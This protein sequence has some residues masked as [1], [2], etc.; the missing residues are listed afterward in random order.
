MVFQLIRLDVFLKELRMRSNSMH[1]NLTLTVDVM[2]PGLQIHGDPTRLTQVFDN[3]IGNAIKY[4]PGS[5]VAISVDKIDE[6]V[7]ITVQD[8]GPG[9]GMEH[10]E[11]IFQRF[12]RVPEH[13]TSARGSGLGLFICREIIQAHDGNIHAESELGHGTTFHIYLPCDSIRNQSNL[14]H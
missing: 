8:Q 9:I 2:T 6:K 3:I 5:P 7:H 10:L 12:F 11:K 13:R 14:D 4:A 1:E